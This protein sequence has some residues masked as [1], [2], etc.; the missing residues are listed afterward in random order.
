ME[1]QAVLERLGWIFARNPRLSLL[2]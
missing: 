1:R 2:P